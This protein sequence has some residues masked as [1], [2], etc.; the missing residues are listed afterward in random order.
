MSDNGSGISPDL[1]PHLFESF[2]QGERT[3]RRRQGGLGLGLAIVKSLTELHGGSVS[4]KTRWPNGGTSFTVRLPSLEQGTASVPPPAPSW[5]VAPRPLRV[6][7]VDD[8]EDAASAMASVLEAAGHD[9]VVLH[10]STVTLA[11]LENVRPDVALLDIGMPGMDGYELARAIR[12]ALGRAAPYL[13]AVTGYGSPEDHQRSSDAGFN[14]HLVK[15]FG[16]ESLLQ[17]V[18]AAPSAA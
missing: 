15:P 18:G 8:N 9:V 6:L 1:L 4:V 17:A 13:I 16:G 10:D 7:V 11:R 5:S 2:V 3:T 14:I 12:S